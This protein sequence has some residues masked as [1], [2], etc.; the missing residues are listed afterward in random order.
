MPLIEVRKEV[1]TE[2]R[3]PGPGRFSAMIYEAR[4]KTFHSRDSL[5]RLAMKNSGGIIKNRD[6]DS[7]FPQRSADCSSVTRGQ[8]TFYFW[9]STEIGGG[10][11]EAHRDRFSWKSAYFLA[12]E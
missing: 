7:T 11:K 1:I 8:S 5:E 4:G 10:G 12:M 3:I 2:L 9:R 6:R